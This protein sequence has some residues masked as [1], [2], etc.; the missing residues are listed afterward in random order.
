MSM[1]VCLYVEIKPQYKVCGVL[2][3]RNSEVDHI[4]RKNMSALP[5]QI[6]F[7]PRYAHC[8]AHAKNPQCER[9]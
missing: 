2:F 3:N 4:L 7:F 1:C 8:Q 9:Q 6:P 5:F